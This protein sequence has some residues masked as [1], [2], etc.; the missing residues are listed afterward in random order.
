MAEVAILTF[1][2]VIMA[3]R[4]FSLLYI[5]LASSVLSFSSIAFIVVGGVMASQVPKHVLLGCFAGLQAV[6]TLGLVV[7]THG[8]GGSTCSPRC[9]ERAIAA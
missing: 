8:L 2:G 6:G 3:D 5:G 1:M 9:W 7:F 4:G